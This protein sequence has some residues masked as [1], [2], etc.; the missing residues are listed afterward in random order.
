MLLHGQEIAWSLRAERHGVYAQNVRVS[1]R[2]V[3]V[4]LRDFAAN[5]CCTLVI[6]VGGFSL[7]V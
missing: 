5:V 7:D 3:D 1:G 4:E 6:D 2:L